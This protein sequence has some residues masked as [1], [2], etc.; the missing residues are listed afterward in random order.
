MSL[1]RYGLVIFWHKEL[2]K[3]AARK[4]LVKLTR[5]KPITNFFRETRSKMV[6]VISLTR[7]FIGHQRIDNF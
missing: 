6:V 3:K 5:G 2:D 1:L 4:M 7:L